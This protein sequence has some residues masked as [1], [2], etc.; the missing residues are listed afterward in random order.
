ML[1]GVARV[2]ARVTEGLCVSENEFL[3]VLVCAR[4]WHCVVRVVCVLW[5]ES[6]CVLSEWEGVELELGVEACEGGRAGVFGSVRG[7]SMWVRGDC[8]APAAVP[9]PYPGLR[10]ALRR[11]PEKG[12]RPSPGQSWRQY[13][14]SFPGGW[15]ERVDDLEALCL[16][17]V[18]GPAVWRAPCP[19]A[20][21]PWQT[22]RPEGLSFPGV[23]PQAQAP[24]SNGSSSPAFCLLSELPFSHLSTFVISQRLFVEPGSSVAAW[25]SLSLI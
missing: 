10:P 5:S 4:L 20:A 18:T 15:V 25:S 22:H 13:I 19:G 23:S 8:G 1:E 24:L 3:S 17:G 16:D 14:T 7:G 9:S 6:V 12:L 21:D 11:R 2:C